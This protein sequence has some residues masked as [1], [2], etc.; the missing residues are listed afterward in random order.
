[1]RCQEHAQN[2]LVLI[3]NDWHRRRVELN[4]IRTGLLSDG[5]TDVATRALS[6]FLYAHWEGGFK[7]SCEIIAGF[8]VKIFER[9]I[10]SFSDCKADFQDF[11]R[12][13][14]LVHIHNKLYQIDRCRLKH[15]NFEINPVKSIKVWQSSIDLE[16]NLTW[17]VLDKEIKKSP[18]PWSYYTLYKIPIEE[19]LLKWRN[20]IVHGQFN[21]IDKSDLENTFDI[22]TS[23]MNDWKKLK[24]K[25]L[26]EE[27]FLK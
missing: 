2:A 15:Q 20:E 23:V 6:V 27:Q 1:M 5:D 7:K 12:Y 17:R 22:V 14:W 11:L 16:S 3:E 26:I 24:E 18:F 9:R 25:F 10:V 4:S 21:S 13:H 8:F 19:R